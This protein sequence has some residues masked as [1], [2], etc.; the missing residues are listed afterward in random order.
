MALSVLNNIPSLVAQNQLEVTNNNLQNTLFQLSSGSKINSGAD[1][2]AGLSIINGLQANISAL[3]QSSQNAT[4]GV[5]QLQVADGALSQVTTLLNRAVTLATEAANGGLTNA[6]FSA[7]TT[8]YGSITSEINRIGA[9]T[10]FNGN[11]VFQ[12]ATVPNPNVS[13]STLGSSLT[14]GVALT[15]GKTFTLNL[16]TNAY[17]YNPG[18]A[19]SAV[20][21]GATSLQ[22]NGANTTLANGEAL[23]ITNGGGTFS[24]TAA[25]QKWGGS[26]T[27][28]TAGTALTDGDTVTVTSTG[29]ANVNFVASSS[30]VSDLLTA[31]NGSAD[32][33]VKAYIDSAGNL[34]ITSAAG[35]NLTVTENNGAKTRLGTL[36]ATSDTVGD[37]M[38]QIDN[39]TY[40][41]SA[42]INGNHLL[43][44]TSTKG[45]VAV[46][47]S[48]LNEVGT[49]TNSST[50]QDLINWING[51][52]TGNEF[53][54]IS[55][56]LANDTNGHAQLT[57]TDNLNRGNLSIT[58][59][60]TALGGGNTTNAF[61]APNM[62][63]AATTDIFISDGNVASSTNYLIPVSIGPL[64]STSIGGQSTTLASASLGTAPGAQAALSVINTAISYVAAMRGTIGAGINRLTSA[65]NV[66]NTQV[67]N[68][69][70]AQSSIQDAN[71]GQV[72]ANLSKYQVLEQTGIA[73]LAQGNSQEQAVLKLLQ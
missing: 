45:T 9:A 63:G 47:S 20:L 25:T 3:Q 37:L 2:P 16:G 57:V 4:D 24:F 19:A 44:I 23:S 1:D 35:D 65:T 5:G 32:T 72:V 67:Q 66:I 27:A 56:G 41:L 42:T 14:G 53:S 51:G 8:E 15:S 31:I 69:T 11:D 12:S 6:Q 21:T 7:I 34:T 13:A 36:A 73:A 70:S 33:N 48:S 18:T 22:A 55:A 68:L 64:S 30:H 50:V 52:G 26:G 39:S 58:D 28:V 71:V 61:A 38:N 43:Q 40:G 60:D 49:I 17:A 10:N 29:G 46:N 59:Y 54:G 62:T